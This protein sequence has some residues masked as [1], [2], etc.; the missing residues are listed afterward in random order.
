MNIS[1]CRTCKSTDLIKAFDLGKQKLTGIFPKS[2]N[3]KVPSGSLA[4]TFC[5][6]CKLLQLENSFNPDV[7]YGENYGY[8]SSLN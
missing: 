6:N 7:M 8:M 5:N 4:M 2:K 3:E 1:N